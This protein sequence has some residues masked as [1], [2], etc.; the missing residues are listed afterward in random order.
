MEYFFLLPNLEFGQ[1]A[2]NNF[3]ER[4]QFLYFVMNGDFL[5]SLK[6]KTIKLYIQEEENL[7][8]IL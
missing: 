1:T 5:L 2:Q 7:P 6:L 4:R 3:E 8:Q